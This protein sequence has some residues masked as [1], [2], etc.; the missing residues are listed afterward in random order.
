MSIYELNKTRR[1]V[2]KFA[3]KPID[4]SLL[5][6]MVDAARVC[7]SGAN[8]QPLRYRI[9]TDD[10]ARAELF[11]HLAWAGYLKDGAPKEGERP[12]AYIVVVQ[13]ESLRSSDAPYDAGAAMM[14]MTLMAHEAG[15]SACWIG[16]V[17]RRGVQE[18]YNLPEHMR[19]VLVLSLGYPAEESRDVSM[20]EDGS[21]RYWL[22]EENVLNVPKRTLEEILF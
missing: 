16:S 21:V 18:L 6:D 10:A 7:P 3:Q 9:V 19:V 14:T 5:R 13:D 8:L 2:R 20:P 4:E 22:D 12:M 1:T 17:N 15:I 11:P